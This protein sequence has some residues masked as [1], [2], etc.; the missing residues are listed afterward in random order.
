MPTSLALANK[1]FELYF[2]KKRLDIEQVES[3]QLA[4]LAHAMS[5]QHSDRSL[6]QTGLARQ[7]L[8]DISRS[9]ILRTNVQ[10]SETLANIEEQLDRLMSL[11]YEKHEAKNKKSGEKRRKPEFTADQ[12]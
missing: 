4:L 11:P 1:A 3:L 7:I 12:A 8:A 10:N 6:K 5:P 9:I 2:G